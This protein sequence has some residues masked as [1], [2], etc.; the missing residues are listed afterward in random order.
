MTLRRA[1]PLLPMLVLGLGLLALRPALAL[2]L[3]AA[4]PPTPRFVAV[5]Q[6][7]SGQAP[8]IALKPHRPLGRSSFTR[9]CC[10]SKPRWTTR[11]PRVTGRQWDTYPEKVFPELFQKQTRRR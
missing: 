1:L 4:S 3:G 11:P 8:W 6:R 10:H 2:P 5:A 9:S 7:H